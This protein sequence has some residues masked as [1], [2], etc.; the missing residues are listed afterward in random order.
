SD[1]SVHYRRSTFR[2][3][4]LPVR[5]RRPHRTDLRI[6]AWSLGGPKLVDGTSGS[7][8]A[9]RPE[10]LPHLVVDLRGHT[11]DSVEAL[12]PFGVRT[13]IRIHIMSHMSLSAEGPRAQGLPHG[14]RPGILKG[15]TVHRPSPMAATRVPPPRRGC[16]DGFPSESSS[17]PA[18]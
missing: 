10:V 4:V 12:L 3:S 7:R 14:V 17:S 6:L 11:L 18:P 15:C 8:S 13:G 5:R 16:S 2:S 1:L 9:R